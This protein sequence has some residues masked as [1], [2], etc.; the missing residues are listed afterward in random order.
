MAPGVLSTTN[1]HEHQPDSASPANGIN[2]WPSESLSSSQRTDR[3]GPVFYSAAPGDVH[4]LVCVGFGP[5]SL[6]IA[7]AL[8]DSL[9]AQRETDPGVPTPT[10]RFLERQAAFKWHAGMLL[11]GA[12][13]QIS[14][15]KDLATLRDPTSHF[16]FLNYLKE[17]DRLVQ[18]SNLGT[19]LPSR[20]EFD[21][22]LQWAARHFEHVVEYSQV[23][24]SIHPRR[25]AGTEKYDCFEVVSRSLAT[26]RTTSFLSRNVVI[27]VG[28][29]PE[30]PTVFPTYHD[31]ILHSSEYNTRISRV[32]PNRDQNY[33]IA[34]VGGGQSAAEVF[35]DLHHRYPNATTRLIIRDSALRPSDDSPFVN[36]VF[37]PEAVDTF[38]DQPEDIRAENVKKNKATNY[39]VV[40]LELLEKLYDDLYIQGIKQPDKRLWQ[41]Q[42]LPLRVISA[43][44]DNGSDERVGLILT[45]LSPSST[46]REEKLSVDVVVLATGYRR[47]AHVDMLRDCQGINSRPD[48]HWQPGRDYGLKLNR[49]SV[50]DG[51]GI[52]LQGC[53]EVTH[54]LSDSLLSILSTRSG[55]LVDSI[56]EINSKPK[57]Y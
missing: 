1:G 21:D 14:F 52:W 16:T 42:I 19:F 3:V 50:Q 22:Y 17:H 37:N 28:G 55:E 41:H 44:D 32:L 24:D 12:K 6:A 56:F 38:F 29:R 43:V 2:G 4:D 9:R 26:G 11:P 45:D 30:R 48:G 34:V 7:V 49:A 13:M 23:V 35:N 5:A 51:I 31:R 25:L 8:H 18:F 39:S 47:D 53:N 54:G 10:V 36:E 27:A 57:G 46:A 15:I 20:L 33:N 40:R